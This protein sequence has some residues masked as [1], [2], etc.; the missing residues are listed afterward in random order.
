MAHAAR[1]FVSHAPE[2]TAWCH[3]FVQALRDAGADV[4]YDENDLGDGVIGA[5]SAR[6]LQARPLCIVI[7]SPAAL[8]SPAVHREVGAAMGVREKAGPSTRSMLLVL[9]EPADVPRVWA[10]YPR[11]SGPGEGGLTAP[12]A[13]RRVLATLTNAPAHPPGAAPVAASSDPA[14]AVGDRATVL[15]TAPARPA[16]TLGPNTRVV[17]LFCDP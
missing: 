14:R 11:V 4:W 2:D 17:Q 13:A 10:E 15:W 8:A 9:A 12:E 7:L 1:I 6:E 3:A 5:E 16:E